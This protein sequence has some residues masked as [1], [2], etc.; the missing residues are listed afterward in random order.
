MR[1]T[2]RILLPES[3]MNGKAVLENLDAK[4][5]GKLTRL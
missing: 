4:I 3:T 1:S 2:T 5:N